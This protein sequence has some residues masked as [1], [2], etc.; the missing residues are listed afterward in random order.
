MQKGGAIYILT[1]NHNRVLYTG[2]TN[3]L[4]RRIFEHRDGLSPKSFSA[5]YNVTK[6]VYFESFHS[7]EEAI[8]R[9]KQIKGGS[10]KK[11]EDLINS[12]NPDW[13]DLWEEIQNW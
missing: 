2:V 10:R 8:S 11:K 6:L 13:K 9:E 3:D 5:K 12:I 1:N 4:V 7:I